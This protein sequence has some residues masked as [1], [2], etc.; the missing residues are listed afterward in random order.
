MFH[1]ALHGLQV[2]ARLSMYLLLCYCDEQRHCCVTMMTARCVPGSGSVWK[3]AWRANL[4]DHKAAEVLQW[5][6]WVLRARLHYSRQQR[7]T[8]VYIFSLSQPGM[9]KICS[10]DVKY[11]TTTLPSCCRC[12]VTVSRFGLGVLDLSGPDK[13]A[14]APCRLSVV[15]T[16]L[17]LI[18]QW[19]FRLL[20][21]HIL[22][23]FLVFAC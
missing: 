15:T 11:S 10:F 19:L 21:W 1:C 23:I 9:T 2:S 6:V 20:T 18:D 13:L 22:D 8:W 14:D 7:K 5:P 4:G 16:R 17:G 3:Y 12:D